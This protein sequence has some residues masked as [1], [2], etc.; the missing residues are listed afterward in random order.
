MRV[1][2]LR[3][4]RMDRFNERSCRNKVVTVAPWQVGL[5]V[6]MPLCAKH[7]RAEAQRALKHFARLMWA[8]DFGKEQG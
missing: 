6:E 1:D 2:D 5:G 3:C 7:A 4:A 8:I